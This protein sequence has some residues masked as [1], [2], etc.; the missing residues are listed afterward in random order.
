MGALR[1]I[2]R[3]DRL[4][5]VDKPAG[6][7]VHSDGTGS[8]TLTDIVRDMLL[9]EGTPQSEHA[10][11][12][13]QAL[14][15]LDRDTIG[16]VLFS[17]DKATQPAYDRLISEHGV[18]KRYLAVVEGSPA[19]RSRTFEGPI[20]RDRHDSRKMRVS[21]TGKPARTV[22]RRVAV[23]DR[24]GKRLALIDVRLDTGRK[25][26]IRVHLSHAGLPILGD[27]LYGSAAPDGLMLHARL[28]R[29]ADPVS[30]EDVVISTGIP[31]RF[32]RLFPSATA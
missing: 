10:T 26:Q 3:S 17:L 11:R 28:M 13:L 7:L 20:G 4:L 31:E 9:K 21:R 16:I 25:H 24:G 19:W 12:D 5:A 29:F 27:A 2:Y 32:E 8:E 23:A 15:R 30:G 22:A 6:M 1:V 18:E 14:Q